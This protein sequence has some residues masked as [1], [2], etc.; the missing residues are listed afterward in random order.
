MTWHRELLKSKREITRFFLFFGALLALT[1]SA[2][3]LQ[4]SAESASEKMQ[5]T[6]TVEKK[7]SSAASSSNQSP[8]IRVL[9]KSYR[10]AWKLVRDNTLFSNRLTHW[11]DWEHR[12]DGKLKTEDDL[13]NAID[14]MVSAVGDQYTFFRNV[15][16]TTKHEER[17]EETGM[18]SHSRLSHNIGYIAIV[19][20]SS[21]NTAD[22]LENALK[23]L[24][25]SSGLIIDLRGNKGGYV[26]QAVEAYE[27]L[28]D[29]GKFISI[30]GRQ[31]G[32]KYLEDIDLEQDCL[33]RDLN[34]KVTVEERRE[35]LAGKKPIL[36]LVDKDTRSA[37]EMLAGALKDNHRAKLAGA[38][39]F[40]KG[41][42][43]NTWKLEPSCS[44]RITIAQYFLP[45]GK[46]I[47][48]LG[49]NP[50]ISV[51]F[52]P[53]DESKALDANERTKHISELENALPSLIK[54][55]I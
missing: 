1:V 28:S 31:D 53:D 16:A 45:S 20:F 2:L 55:L 26:E 27:L 33:R 32:K 36:V 6:M 22:E 13:K 29:E 18:V 34:G 25:N 24:K 40:G 7:T 8:S 42:V 47:N 48:G 46:C 49:L 30:R 35:N 39:T 5:A 11:E 37:A 9:E 43:Q 14:K 3:P 23:K 38:R 21:T 17:D 51:K 52:P 12:F 50:D 10:Q 41:V 19:G 4:S 54:S 15:V 44:I